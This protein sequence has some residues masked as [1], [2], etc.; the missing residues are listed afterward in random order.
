VATS[1]DGFDSRL[2]YM[3]SNKQQDKLKEITDS[4]E[5]STRAWYVR[6]EMRRLHYSDVWILRFVAE[7]SKEQMMNIEYE[8]SSLSYAI[9]K[10]HNELT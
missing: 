3:L 1:S 9:R 7:D 8:A 2:P 5:S 6:Y 4:I 10:A